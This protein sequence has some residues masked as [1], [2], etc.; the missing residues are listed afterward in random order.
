M[1]VSAANRCVVASQATSIPPKAHRRALRVPRAPRVEFIY[2]PKFRIFN[3]RI[4]DLCDAPT[5]R[6]APGPGECVDDFDTSLS[7]AS[8]AAATKGPTGIAAAPK[9]SHNAHCVTFEPRRRYNMSHRGRSRG[10]W[11]ERC[12]YLD[13]KRPTAATGKEAT[14]R[15]SGYEESA[16]PECSWTARR[17]PRT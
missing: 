2:T 9:S 17:T 5:I 12:F 1:A 14:I 8:R 10:P 7:V 16:G 4:K 15:A 6:P 11:H 3:C 13:Q